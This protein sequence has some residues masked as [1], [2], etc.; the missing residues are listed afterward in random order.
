MYSKRIRSLLSQSE[1]N[2]FTKLNSFKKI[3]DFLDTL[4]V[5][6]ETT[7]ETYMSPRLV[8]RTGTAHCLE[9]AL[10][11]AAACAYH[12]QRPLLM[13]FQTG[14]DDEDH[15]VALF[16]YK[17]LW[18]AFSK[19][20]H[21]VLRYRDPIY[22]TVRELAMS[23]FHEYLMWDGRK[24]LRTYSAPFDLSRFAPD[25]WITAE[26]DLFDLVGE[27]DSSKHFPIV[28]KKN[29]ISLRRASEIELRAMKLTE[30]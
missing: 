22:K 1:K 3:Q 21:S 12:G 30:W 23:Y 19:T 6:F 28:S 7:G 24:S 13:D 9:G 4:P 16:R 11:A 18:G 17:G 25:T 20:N 14:F 2:L 15:V 29:L 8:L 26:T 10:L 5:N 27:L